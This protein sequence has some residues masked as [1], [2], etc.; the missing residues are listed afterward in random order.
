MRH[1]G[2]RV[3]RGSPGRGHGGGSGGGY[4]RWRLAPL[5]ARC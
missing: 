3:I 4:S 1:R 5:L 2:L